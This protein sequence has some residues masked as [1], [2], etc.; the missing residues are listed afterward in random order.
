MNIEGWRWTVAEI[1]RREDGVVEFMLRWR[2]IPKGVNR[3]D[4]PYTLVI[5]WENR[6]STPEGL[7]VERE[8]EAMG[9]FELRLGEAVERDS[10][11]V[12]SLA[13]TGQNEREL[14]FHTRDVEEFSKRLHEMPE[15]EERYPIRIVKSDDPAWTHVDETFARFAIDPSKKPSAWEWLK[16]LVG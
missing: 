5:T 3:S 4:W 14:V 13:V 1:F 6:F 9:T 11:A 8:L 10:L 12:M 16:S 15:E 7:P 2:T